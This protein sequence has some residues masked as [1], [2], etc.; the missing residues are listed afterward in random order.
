M[1]QSVMMMKAFEARCFLSLIFSGYQEIMEDPCFAADGYTYERRVIEQWLQK[2]DT[3]PMTN[4][5]LNH[6]DVTPNYAVRSAIKDWID[7]T[8]PPATG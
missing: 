5:R 2:H 7:K 1:K 4:L 3:S 6:K 8:T